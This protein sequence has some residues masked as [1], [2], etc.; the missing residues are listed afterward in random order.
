VI[1]DLPMQRI[2]G[3]I[4]ASLPKPAGT[5][6]VHRDAAI[7][8]HHTAFEMRDHH[9]SMIPDWMSFFPPVAFLFE[10]KSYTD[11]PDQLE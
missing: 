5:R 3:V 9:R 7:T 6:S 4:T 2:T 11:L 10:V 8:G 1:G